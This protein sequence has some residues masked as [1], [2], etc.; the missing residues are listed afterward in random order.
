MKSFVVFSA[1]LSLHTDNPDFVH[2]GSLVTL[3][4]VKKAEVGGDSLLVDAFNVAERLRDRNPEAFEYL[5]LFW[6][7]GFSFCFIPF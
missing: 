5:V 6:F 1:Y 7:F 3:Q 4:P 2:P